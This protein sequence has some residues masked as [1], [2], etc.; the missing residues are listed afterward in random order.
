MA[1][2]PSLIH[3]HND[4]EADALRVTLRDYLWPDGYPSSRLPDTVTSD[5]SIPF[6]GVNNVPNVL[7]VDKL[8]STISSEPV[9][10]WLLRP[11]VASGQLFI[12]HQGH[13][14]TFGELRL[15][16]TVR[17]ALYR[18]ATVIACLMPEVPH[19]SEPLASFLE[20]VIASLNY[21]I[22]NYGPFT[23][24][25][26]S[27][28]SGGGWTTD[29]VCALDTRIDVG[30]NIHGSIPLYMRED[31]RGDGGDHEQ[32]HT[33]LNGTANYLDRYLMAAQ[34]RTYIQLLHRH[35]GC[36][37]AKYF[38]SAETDPRDPWYE[39]YES[40]LTAIFPGFSVVENTEINSVHEIRD[41]D[42]DNVLAQHLGSI[43]WT[44]G[45]T[46][47]DTAWVYVPNANG[48]ATEWR[49]A[50][51]GVL[52]SASHNPTQA[53]FNG[54]RTATL[55][56]GSLAAGYYELFMSWLQ[57]GNRAT[58]TPVEVFDNDTSRGT[59]TLDQQKAPG[60]HEFDGLSW[61]SIGGYQIDSGT[62]KVVVTDDADGFVIV[63]ALHYKQAANP[64][65]LAPLANAHGDYV[66]WAGHPIQFRATGSD[67][68]GSV[69][70]YA[71]DFGD[72]SGTS[73]DQNPKYTYAAA[74]EYTVTLTVTD[75]LGAETTDEATVVVA[76]AV[77]ESSWQPSESSTGL[78]LL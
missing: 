59:V 20:N 23:K 62:L 72:G 26:M 77:V 22:N 33:G 25:V 1:V 55:T 51:S 42:R 75:D 14:N 61:T 30:I 35:D 57:S 38:T 40:A 3:V 15:Q 29:M 58:N 18:G 48:G 46:V 12:L 65:N 31:D 11:R 7:Q 13:T 69:A 60:P 32:N 52:N 34:D 68:D 71:W 37:F 67:P 5:V 44:D 27:G 8:E 78:D 54:D 64:T 17:W 39:D 2:D 45:V 63:D 24:I 73:S 10:A 4:T 41:W 50:A 21:T 53:P 36:C 70:S 9:D 49:N 6:S 47:D 43:A 56:V 16:E 28:L 76:A 74:G 66:G 19:V